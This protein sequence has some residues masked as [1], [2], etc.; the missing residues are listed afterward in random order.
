MR[1]AEL[2]EEEFRKHE[3][4]LRKRKEELALRRHSHKPG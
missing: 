3:E 1:G 2:K 4:S